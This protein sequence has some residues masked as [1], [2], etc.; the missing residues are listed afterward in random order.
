MSAARPLPRRAARPVRGPRTAALACAALVLVGCTA[1]GPDYTRPA[2]ALPGAYPEQAAGEAPIVQARWWTLYGDPTLTRLVDD[3][4]ARNADVRLAAAR[5][6]ETEAV[7][8]QA[9]AALFPQIDLQG[10]STRTRSSQ[11]GAV[12]LPAS[13]PIVQ[14]SQRLV[15]STSFELDF[16][17]R[18]R[19]ADEAARAQALGSRYGEGVV[20]TTLAGATTQAYFALRSLEA[21][22]ASLASSVGAREGSLDLARR[23]AAGGVASDLDVA[24]AAGALADARVQ[25]REL[26]RQR[27]LVEHQLAV[28]TGRPGERVAPGLALAALPVVPPTP[29]GLPSSLVERRPDVRQA[30][31]TLAAASALIGV[32][33]AQEYPTFSL[34]ALLGG[35]AADLGNV[36]SGAGRVGSLGASVF[37]PVFDAGRFKA[38]TREAEARAEQAA[39]VYERTVQTAWREVADALDTLGAAAQSEADVEARRLAAREALRITQIRYESGYS[40]YL[41]VLDA[42]RTLNAAELASIQNRQAR[43]ASSV[44]LMKALGGGW[45]PAPAGAGPVAGTGEAGSTAGSAA[46]GAATGAT[47]P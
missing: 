14:N 36:I 30:E 25:Q 46:G 24:Q 34:T 38:R 33:K 1:V 12:P 4:L 2:V 9:R 28:L 17:G 45:Q 13:A 7:L 19:R 35:Q 6:Q 40:G 8:D 31:Q 29:P 10:S 26:L 41:E 11:V 37:W 42:Q 21:Q 27:A 22:A 43:L 23:R 47:K 32:A 44:D 3:A 39:A 18:L 15:L 5:V 20:A 16:W